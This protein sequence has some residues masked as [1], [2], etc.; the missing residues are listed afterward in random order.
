MIH[1]II[2]WAGDP[3]SESPCRMC[4]PSSR[5]RLFDAVGVGL[6]F[7]CLI[8][9]LALPLLLLL[10][11]ALAAWLSLPEWIHAAILLLATPA[12]AAAMTDGWRGHRRLAP[13]LLA[14]S[15]LTLLGLGLA[16]HA[17]W[18]GTLDPE[19]ADRW[20]TS[21]GAL[22]LAAAHLANWRLRHR[23][24]AGRGGAGEER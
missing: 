12:A 23:M 10:A 18:L 1:Y 3:L 21:A 8:H 11:P 2:I 24:P 7:A 6:S 9:C 22:G 14:A 15:G 4:L 16:G 20:F 17:G 13:G 5:A 19:A